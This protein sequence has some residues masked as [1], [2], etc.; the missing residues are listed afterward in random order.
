[1]LGGQAGSSSC[2]A[3]GLPAARGSGRK[4]EGEGLLLS[5]PL[6]E[7]CWEKERKEGVEQDD[8]KFSAARHSG[9]KTGGLVRGRSCCCGQADR[10]SCWA[11][12]LP[13]AWGNGRKRGEA[14]FELLAARGALRERMNG[15]G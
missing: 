12:G 10:C 15:V 3:A 6:R 2:W 1:M 5:F 13:A 14:A 9:R 4:R 11:A 8:C 7:G